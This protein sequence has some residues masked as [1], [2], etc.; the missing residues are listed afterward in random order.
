MK[1]INNIEDAI[2]KYNFQFTYHKCLE[3]SKPI[4][5]IDLRNY[6]YKNKYAN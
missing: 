4:D 6:F 1:R 3:A 5:A 2:F